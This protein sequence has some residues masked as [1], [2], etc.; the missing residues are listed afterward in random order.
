MPRFTRSFHVFTIGFCLGYIN[1]PSLKADYPWEA[2]PADTTFVVIPGASH[3][4]FSAYGAQP[5][6]GTPTIDPVVAQEQV[7][8]AAVALLAAITPEPK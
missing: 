3:A 4:S 2:L 6:D 5:G 1:L 7:A 8:A